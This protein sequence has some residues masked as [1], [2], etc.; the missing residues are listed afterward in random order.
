MEYNSAAVRMCPS[1][2][3][4]TDYKRGLLQPDGE[5]AVYL[6]HFLLN[7]NTCFTTSTP[8]IAGLLIVCGVPSDDTFVVHSLPLY[9]HVTHGG[10]VCYILAGRLIN[11]PV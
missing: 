11:W 3:N 6:A 10:R 1:Y 4:N 2:K 8:V 9:T 7:V 5:T